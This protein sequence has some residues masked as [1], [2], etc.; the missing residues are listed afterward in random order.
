MVP[1]RRQLVFF[2][3]KT[4]DLIMMIFS[5]FLSLYIVNASVDYNSFI[6]ILSMRV[7][8]KNFLIFSGI[9]VIW[10]II[11]TR[12]GLYSKYRLS[13]IRS[14]AKNILWIVSFSTLLLFLLKILFSISMIN[15]E[16]LV[17]FWGLNC[18]LMILGRLAIKMLLRQLRLNGRNLRTILFIGINNRSL[19]LASKI[20]ARPELGYRILGFVDDQKSRLYDFPIKHLPFIKFEEL[21]V[22]LQNNVVDEIMVCLPLKSFYAKASEVISSCEEQGIIVRY[23]SEQFDMKHAKSKTTEFLDNK[24]ITLYTGEMEGD[25]MILKRVFDFFLSLTL[26]IILSPVFLLTALLIKYTS[27]GPVFF[28]QERIG[29]NK[30]RFR[31]LKFRTMFADAEKGMAELEHLN[32]ATGP[33]FKIRNDP[34]ITPIGKFLRKTSIDE[35]PQLFNVLVGD[36]SLVGPRP[37]PVRDYRGFDKDWHRRRFSVRPGIT[38]LWQINGR[39]NI[40]FDKWMELDMQY[41][42]NWSFWLDLKILLETIPAVLKGSG[43]A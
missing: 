43:A 25:T 38:C 13:S 16:F 29:L 37:L 22:Y 3:L 15:W 7:S 28:F 12:S 11:Y 24:I 39:S 41:I 35:L 19:C 30:R 14:I 36:M 18:S 42:D 27:P 10:H 23:F 1:L 2:A 20:A 4:F 33:V 5:F 34:R 9:V 40:S 32:E 6:E 8:V 17:V 31:I 21:Q 26:I